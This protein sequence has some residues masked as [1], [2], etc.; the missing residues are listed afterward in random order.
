MCTCLPVRRSPI[1]SDFYMT[2][3]GIVSGGFPA[4]Y[5]SHVN[6]ATY[7]RLHGLVYHWDTK[8]RDGLK[9]PHFHKISAVLDVL[10]RH[11]WVLWLDD[12]AFFTD[13]SQDMRRFVDDVPD[14]I[15]FVACRSP[16]NPQGGWTL[17]NSGVFFIRNSA[18]G[19]RLLTETLSTTETEVNANWKP[20]I[21]GLLTSGEQDHIIHVLHRD[22]LLGR[23]ILHDWSAFNARPYHWPEGAPAELYPVVHFP[24]TPGDREEAIAAFA[25]RF[26]RDAT[27]IAV[28]W[29]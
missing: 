8:K 5:S 12:D 1:S 15:F 27:M 16:I 20:D 18:D 7:A 22:G 2:N 29:R 6:H 23:I 19:R 28:E 17:L 10:D 9:T 24:G 25:A 14:D 11:D 3:L 13:L 26:G 21:Y 4:R